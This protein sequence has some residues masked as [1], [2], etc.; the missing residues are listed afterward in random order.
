MKKLVVYGVG[1][2]LGNRLLT[3]ASGLVYAKN[4]NRKFEMIWHTGG[5]ATIRKL[6]HCECKSEKL[7]DNDFF[8]KEED[9]GKIQKV[10]DLF[11]LNRLMKK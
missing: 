1:C 6:S 2:G 9:S 10:Y 8:L 3:I 11:Y 4:T 7:F 5:T